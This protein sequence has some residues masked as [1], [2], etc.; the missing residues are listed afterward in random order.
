[1]STFVHNF[2]QQEKTAKVGLESVAA[3]R[4]ALGV[5]MVLW[6]EPEGKRVD[7]YFDR[8]VCWPNSGIGKAVE[9][10]GGKV[11]VIRAV[12][13]PKVFG[14]KARMAETAWYFLSSRDGGMH[15]KDGALIY[16]HA[17]IPYRHP[18]RLRFV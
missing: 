8:D 18:L 5:V 15:Y 11:G 3:H 14:R 17:P 6:H 16:L 12:L 4:I 10:G 2:V 1:M 13:G 9:D 7:L